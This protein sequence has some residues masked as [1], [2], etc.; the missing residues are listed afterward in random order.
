MAIGE[1]FVDEVGPLAQFRVLLREA[2]G[3]PLDVTQLLSQLDLALSHLVV[4]SI[5]PFGERLQLFHPLCEGLFALAEALFLLAERGGQAMQVTD[6]GVDHRLVLGELQ[7]LGLKL[8]GQSMQLVDALVG[9]DAGGLQFADL[10]FERLHI[11]VGDFRD[12][13]IDVVGAAV[14]HA[15][16]VGLRRSHHFVDDQVDPLAIDGLGVVGVGA[17]QQI[18]AQVVDQ[19]RDAVG[20]LMNQLDRCILE[21]LGIVL[22]GDLQS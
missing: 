6:L 9:V 20:I 2:G 10:G 13:L 16:V 11:L 1:L 5:E 8:G 15:G 7:F 4:L 3:Q 14:G 17:E 22:P 19:S 18:V 21:D 12:G